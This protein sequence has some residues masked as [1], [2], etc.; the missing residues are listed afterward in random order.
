LL[1][2]CALSS[3]VT[4]NAFA[5]DRGWA[6]NHPIAIG[7]R[8]SGWF[9]GYNAPGVGGHLQMRPFEWVGVETFADSFAMGSAEAVRHDHV[10]GFGLYFP[11]LIGTRSFFVSPALGTCVDFRF[12]HDLASDR[13]AARDILFGIHAGAMAELY[14]WHGFAVELSAKAYAYIGHDSGHDRWT[15]RISN[16]LELTWQGQ[17]L[18]GINY[19]F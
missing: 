13:P 9:G 7:A 18:G 2:W 1:L 4:S 8:A 19:Y 10:I 17:L 14:V 15:T 3:L 11:T 5:R 6:D 16:N 12:Q